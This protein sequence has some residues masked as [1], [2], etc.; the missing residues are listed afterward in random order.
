M[1]REILDPKYRPPRNGQP[2]QS[3]GSTDGLRQG[4]SPSGGDGGVGGELSQEEIDARNAQR[5]YRLQLRARTEWEMRKRGEVPGQS[6][7]A[8]AGARA[9]GEGNLPTPLSLTPELPSPSPPNSN[10]GGLD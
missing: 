6:A 7:V 9:S 10:L 1:T 2:Q 3:R 5:F 4:V 8:A